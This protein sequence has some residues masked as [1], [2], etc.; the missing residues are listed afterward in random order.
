MTGPWLLGFIGV[1]FVCFRLRTR[2]VDHVDAHE[3]TMPPA[4]ESAD[5]ERSPWP[6]NLVDQATNSLKTLIQ[7]YNNQTT[8]WLALLYQIFW[9]L[10]LLHLTFGDTHAV[11]VLVAAVL[12]VYERSTTCVL[13]VLNYFMGTARRVPMQQKFHAAAA[14]CT[15]IGVYAAV[16][17]GELDQPMASEFQYMTIRSQLGLPF[18][19]FVIGYLQVTHAWS[20]RNMLNAV[21]WGST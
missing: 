1:E 7:T 19:S 17:C 10:E 5:G 3:I 9:A 18:V 15:T 11:A 20:F 2:I 16:V 8:P 12:P 13:M 21:L 4:P 14:V 6:T